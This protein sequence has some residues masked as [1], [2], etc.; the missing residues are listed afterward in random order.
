LR[1]PPQTSLRVGGTKPFHRSLATPA[2]RQRFPPRQEWVVGESNGA[3]SPASILF[4]PLNKLIP[5]ALPHGSSRSCP[6]ST[7]LPRAIQIRRAGLAGL[8][9]RSAA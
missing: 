7:C 6:P 1:H 8:L 3:K 4:H 5:Q 2:S 9:D